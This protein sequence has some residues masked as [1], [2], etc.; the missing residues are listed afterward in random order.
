MTLRPPQAS[1][2][3]PRATETIVSTKAERAARC[4]HHVMPIKIR[5][6]Q[7]DG[8][9]I[10]QVVSADVRVDKPRRAV[11]LARRRTRTA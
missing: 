5:V 9:T 8:S 11:R 10:I 7:S 4:K 1:R 3:T 2:G 6:R